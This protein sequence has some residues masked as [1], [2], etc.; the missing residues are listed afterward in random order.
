MNLSAQGYAKLNEKLN[1]DIAVLEGGYSIEGALSY[2]NLGIILAMTGMDYSN[3]YEPNFHK[4]SL[5]Q[6]EDITTY[7]EEISEVIYE[8]WK[9]KEALKEKE[10]KGLEYV[11]RSRQVYYETDGISDD[12]VQ[13]FKVCDQC[14]GV[15]SIRSK[16]DNGHH[17]L[18]V[19]IPRESCSDCMDEGYKLYKNSSASYT[20]VYLQDK[21]QDEYY[22][23]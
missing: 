21:A 7:I 4:E 3:V 15:N 6:S 9:N 5:K 16:A 8:R 11:E 19:T 1:P 13:K 18:A 12:Q 10:L 23:K 17:V 22:S 20:D 2:V 14:S